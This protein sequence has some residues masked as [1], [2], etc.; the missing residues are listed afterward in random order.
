MPRPPYTFLSDPAVRVNIPDAEWVYVIRFI[1]FIRCCLDDYCR[2][3]QCHQPFYREA[4]L[5][6]QCYV[7]FRVNDDAVSPRRQCVLALASL[8][9][10]AVLHSRC[11]PTELETGMVHQVCRAIGWDE[12]SLECIDRVQGILQTYPTPTDIFLDTR[13]TDNVYVHTARQLWE[14]TAPACPT[15]PPLNAV[16]D[17]FSASPFCL[18]TVHTGVMALWATYTQTSAR[19]VTGSLNDYIHQSVIARRLLFT[20]QPE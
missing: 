17:T 2:M 18:Q 6:L 14:T 20:R 10:A 1:E 15:S 5:A 7:S 4:Y 13:L 11:P 12:L 9:L 8:H 3:H 19:R 16:D